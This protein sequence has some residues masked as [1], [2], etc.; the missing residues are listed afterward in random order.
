MAVREE[1]GRF[2]YT[3]ENYLD[4]EFDRIND[5]LSTQIANTLK[6]EEF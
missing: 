2:N 4:E 1:I 5:Q 6:K 3:H